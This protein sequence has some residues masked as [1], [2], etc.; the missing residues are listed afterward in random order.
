MAEKKQI[1]I[2]EVEN[3]FIV[4]LDYRYKERPE[5]EVPPDDVEFVTTSLELALNRAA[6][7]LAL[8]E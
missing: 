1:R 5:G 7:F 8:E 3:G 2:R 4:D 6:A